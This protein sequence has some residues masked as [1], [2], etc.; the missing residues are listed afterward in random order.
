VYTVNGLH[1]AS[2]LKAGDLLFQDMNETP[3]SSCRVIQVTAETNE[4]LYFGLNCLE[5]EVIA[6]GIKA[7][8]FGRCH[9]IPALWMKYASHV[10]GVERA[11]RWGDS[12]VQM[13]I[14]MKLF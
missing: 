7:S 11:S 2:T 14:R 13:L 9:T 4:Q 10:L 1:P 3:S 6:N 8:T 12:F 5:S